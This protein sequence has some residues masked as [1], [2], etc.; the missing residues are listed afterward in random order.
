MYADKAR[1]DYALG[2]FTSQSKLFCA[3]WT[4]LRTKSSPARPS[5]THELLAQP[6][7]GTSVDPRTRP[8]F[9]GNSQ[10][11]ACVQM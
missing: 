10:W 7:R 9:V 2:F 1:E 3:R 11:S 5:T 4:P 6:S 8:S